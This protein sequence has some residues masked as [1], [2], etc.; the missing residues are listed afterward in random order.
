MNFFEE[1]TIFLFKELIQ[2]CYFSSKYLLSS[3]LW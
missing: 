3:L 2:L 1:D